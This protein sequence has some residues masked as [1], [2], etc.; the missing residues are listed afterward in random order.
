MWGAVS[1]LPW[2]QALP[3]L[4][5]SSLLTHFREKPSQVLCPHGLWEFNVVQMSPYPKL[6]YRLAAVAAAAKSLQLCLA[7][8]NP[9][10]CSLPGSPVHGICQGR[11][12]EWV[13][14][15]FSVY[16]LNTILINIYRVFYRQMFSL[17]KTCMEIQGTF[18]FKRN[19]VK[20]Q[21]GLILTNFKTL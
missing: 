10:D 2:L 13:A 17:F 4:L 20:E 7:L 8:C 15:A 9:M 12:L 6:L 11:V 21:K 16:R 18:N 5:P 3:Y 14:I 1:T 19:L